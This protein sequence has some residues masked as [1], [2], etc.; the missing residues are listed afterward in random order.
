MKARFVE[1]AWPHLGVVL[2]PETD[3]ERLLL[4]CWRQQADEPNGD[5]KTTRG[6]RI[7]SY[8]LGGDRPG[9]N[10]MTLN[11]GPWIPPPPPSE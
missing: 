4:R 2:T 1:G 3:D 7:G 10:S 6:I 5:G 9:V 11:I 8:G